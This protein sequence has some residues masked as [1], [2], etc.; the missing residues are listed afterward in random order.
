MDIMCLHLEK[1]GML[2]NP[3]EIRLSVNPNL[4]QHLVIKIIKL[5]Y[6]VVNT[7]L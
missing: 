3:I 6:R 1:S 7:V 2:L 4:I 5:Q